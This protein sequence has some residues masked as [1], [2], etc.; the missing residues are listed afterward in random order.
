MSNEPKWDQVRANP[1]LVS[2]LKGG[3]KQ[4]AESIAADTGKRVELLRNMHSTLEKA[5]LMQ[6]KA[7]TFFEREKR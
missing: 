4:F 5:K 6:E 2:K 1:A 3:L 7:K